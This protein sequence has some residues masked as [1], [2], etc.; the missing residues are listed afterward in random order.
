MV[1]YEYRVLDGKSKNEIEHKLNELARKGYR[2]TSFN[3]NV[4]YG[5]TTPHTAVMER[6]IAA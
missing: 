2:L 6:Q 4:P 1:R 3:T 5:R